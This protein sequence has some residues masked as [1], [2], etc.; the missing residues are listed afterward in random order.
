MNRRI[1]PIV[2]ISLLRAL[3]AFALKLI[4]MDEREWFIRETIEVLGKSLRPPIQFNLNLK[5]FCSVTN[6]GLNTA[7]VLSQNSNFQT[8]PSI[9]GIDKVNRYNIACLQVSADFTRRT[10]FTAAYQRLF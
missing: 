4:C 9:N 5:M 3:L 6:C 2:I 10:T 1:H 8:P 7:N